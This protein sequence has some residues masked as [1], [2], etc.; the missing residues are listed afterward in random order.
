VLLSGRPAVT[1]CIIHR[2]FFLLN[3]ATFC[4]LFLDLTCLGPLNFST[5][6]VLLLSSETQ[7]F[8]H[9][10]CLRVIYDSQNK[11][12]MRYHS[13]YEPTNAHDM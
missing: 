11:H 4:D 1:M 12:L 6:Y 7:H 10:T 8:A 9:K 3:S 13:L 5:Y 2:H